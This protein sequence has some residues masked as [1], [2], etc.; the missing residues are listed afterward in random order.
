MTSE[1]PI[2]LNQP[3][4][5]I[6]DTII[7]ETLLLSRKWHQPV[8]RVAPVLKSDKAWEGFFPCL[9]GSVLYINNQFHMWYVS[10]DKK[11]SENCICY[12]VSDNGVDWQKPALKLVEWEG[13]LENN[14]IYKS[15]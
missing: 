4:L 6:N 11:E 10:L 2:N 1:V 5:F 7:E 14:I 3:A 9:Y 8:K 12:A 13:S 15:I